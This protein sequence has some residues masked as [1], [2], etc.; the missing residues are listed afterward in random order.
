[1]PAL[2]R[3][4]LCLLSKLHHHVYIGPWDM[5]LSPPLVLMLAALTVIVCL[6]LVCD[7]GTDDDEREQGEMQH[8]TC[9]E[10][11]RRA[12]QRAA[13]LR[14]RRSNQACM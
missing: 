5:V 3:V 11:G 10:R 14:E 8:G 2:R 4:A 13:A 12:R 9:E 6:T 1:M 7:Q